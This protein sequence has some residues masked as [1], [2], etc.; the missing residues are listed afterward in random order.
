M[1]PSLVFI[2]LATAISAAPFNRIAPPQ[3]V[4]EVTEIID[5]LPTVGSVAAAAKRGL[6]PPVGPVVGKV[7]AIFRGLPVVDEVAKGL[8]LGGSWGESKSGLPPLVG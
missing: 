5:T 4:G 3:G 2:S 7:A 6:P 8:P 1:R